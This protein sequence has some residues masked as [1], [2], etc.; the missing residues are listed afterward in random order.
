MSHNNKDCFYDRMLA[1]CTPFERH[2]FE[3]GAVVIRTMDLA[4]GAIG[5]AVE[6]TSRD[7]FTSMKNCSEAELVQLA[8]NTLEVH[9]KKY[10]QKFGAANFKRCMKRR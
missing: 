3:D 2:L 8:H 5:E 10:K 6:M 4:T 9:K 1:K 7:W